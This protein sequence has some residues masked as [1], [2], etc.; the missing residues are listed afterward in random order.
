GRCAIWWIK[1]YVHGQPVKESTRTTDE[2][3]ARRLLK[4]REGRA[5]RGEPILPR[6]D[7][8]TFEEAL[9]DLRTHY[10]ATGKRDLKEFARR[11][12]PLV[13]FFAARR[14][15]TIGQADVDKYVVLRRG[16]ARTGST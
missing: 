16:Q 5:A 9:A 1:Y 11:V 2:P 13:K 4:E 15:A 3:E 14:I 7:R 10:E 8:V 12:P 6:V